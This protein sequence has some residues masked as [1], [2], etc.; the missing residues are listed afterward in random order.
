MV[1]DVV[2]HETKFRRRTPGGLLRVTLALLCLYIAPSASQDGGGS[3][4]ERTAS[5]NDVKAAFLLNF[6]SFVE[7]P[8]GVGGP[9]RG[10]F[11]ICVLGDDPFRGSLDALVVGDSFRDRP[12]Q[13]RHIRRWQEP[14]NV[15]FV[16]RT[17]Q[18]P[19]PILRRVDP[20]VLTVGEDPDFL[21]AGGMIN[22]VVDDRRVRFDVNLKAAEEG[23]V[24]ISSRLLSVARRV[25]Q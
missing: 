23:S 11:S 19:L 20:G 8:P 4:V 21:R 22:F 14:C 7:W 10:P 9:S 13:V 25:E 1:E 12:I 15:L 18:G 17:F 5:E 16:S 24:K 2:K 6:V 3:A